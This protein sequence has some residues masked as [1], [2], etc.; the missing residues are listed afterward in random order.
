MIDTNTYEDL[1]IR[2]R[3]VSMQNQIEYLRVKVLEIFRYTDLDLTLPKRILE[4][5]V[6]QE[7][8]TI[9]YEH[10]GNLYC[11]TTEPSGKQDV[12]GECHEVHFTHTNEGES[13]PMTRTIGVDAVMVRN[14][15]SRIGLDPLLTELALMMAQAKITA[16]DN[17]MTL[18]TNRIIQAKDERSYASA[19]EYEK[20][21]RD[22]A[23]AVILA[24][25]FDAMEGINVHS[26][27]IPSNAATQTIELFQY[28][29]SHYYSELGITLNNNMKSQYVSESELGKSTGM[30]LIYNML[31]CRQDAIDEINALF[32]RSIKVCLSEEWNDELEMDEEPAQEM[33]EEQ[34]TENE[35]P[36]EGDETDQP[37][38]SSDE[39]DEPDEQETPVEEQEQEEHSAEEVIDAAEAMIGVED[40]TT[41]DSSS[42]D[43]DS[44]ANS[45]EGDEGRDDVETE[46]ADD[47][48]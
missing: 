39:Q 21:I 13:I 45:D 10:E 41:D 5:R 18:R 38:D 26:T 15:A 40:E 33:P 37:V 34:E 14:D 8:F 9:V 29:S 6:T 11:T 27:P 23:P 7:G 47:E 24:E 36:A 16:L 1:L 17:F 32:N 2:N 31:A 46:D 19:V 30:P 48:D 28:I 22:G 3:L 42:D 4:S 35:E 12:Y 44:E 25:E 20:Q 43:A